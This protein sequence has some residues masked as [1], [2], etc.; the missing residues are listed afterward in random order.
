MWLPAL[1]AA[2][3]LAAGLYWVMREPTPEPASTEGAAPAASQSA[4]P[5]APTGAPQGGGG[6]HA[7]HGH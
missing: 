1:G 4:K 7:G 3:F 2:L 6:G 5:A